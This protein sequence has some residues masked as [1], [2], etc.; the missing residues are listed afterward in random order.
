ML[1]LWHL[2]VSIFA[3]LLRKELVR[4][5]RVLIGDS[6]CLKGARTHN[7][8]EDGEEGVLGVASIVRLA[9]EGKPTRCASAALRF[10][11]HSW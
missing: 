1:V 2:E 11:E 6:G 7:L 9:S 8:A 3:S 4:L 10:D 5:M